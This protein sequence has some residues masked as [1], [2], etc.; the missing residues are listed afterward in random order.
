MKKLIILALVLGL[1]LTAVTTYLLPS[2]MSIDDQG[3][4]CMSLGGCDGTYDNLSFESG[5]PLRVK[6]EVYGNFH[7]SC[8][9][10][11]GTEVEKPCLTRIDSQGNEI[12]QG[13]PT[14]QNEP[15]KLVLNFIFFCSLSLLLFIF[16]RA[17]LIRFKKS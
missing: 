6:K 3:D 12:Y 7:A 10:T 2:K 17:V 16:L 8:L 11:T 9:D 1:T 14:I 15:F 13:S 5:W 4:Q